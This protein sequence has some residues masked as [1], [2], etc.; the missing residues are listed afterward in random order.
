M[1]AL[2]GEGLKLDERYAGLRVYNYTDDRS[3]VGDLESRTRSES[4]SNSC[5]MFVVALVG[6]QAADSRLLSVLAGE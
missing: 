6:Q 4:E 5:A 2:I 1:A 3:T